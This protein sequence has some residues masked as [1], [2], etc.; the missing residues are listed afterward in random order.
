HFV[1]GRSQAVEREPHVQL[2]LFLQIVRPHPL[3]AVLR[4]GFG[5]PRVAAAPIEDRRPHRM[6]LK[7]NT[8]CDPVTR[9]SS[10]VYGPT[11]VGKWN[12]GIGTSTWIPSAPRFVVALRSVTDASKSGS[13]AARASADRPCACFSASLESWI[14]EFP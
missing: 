5:A 3:G 11:K 1:F 4:A 14:L 6:A 9:A 12:P 2:H 8:L 10:V 13:N 7:S